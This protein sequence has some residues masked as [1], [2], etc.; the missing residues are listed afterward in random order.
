MTCRVWLHGGRDSLPKMLAARRRGRDRSRAGSYRR[1]CRR[2]SICRSVLPVLVVARAAGRS[3][4]PT[5]IGRQPAFSERRR[6]GGGRDCVSHPP[7]WLARR[8]RPGQSPACF[9]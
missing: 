5:E 6:Q 1:R 9:L 7:G 2:P 3:P 4:L 8:R